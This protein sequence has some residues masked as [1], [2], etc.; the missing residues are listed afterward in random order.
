[1]M[2]LCLLTACGGTDDQMQAA[3]DLRTRLL[4]DGCSYTAQVTA[5]CGETAYTFT[6]ACRSGS[7][8]T[9]FTVLEP[10]A[11]AGI[12]ASMATGET[13]VT[14]DDMVLVFDDLAAGTVSAAAAPG[15][16]YSSWTGGY[17]QSCGKEGD[18][19]MATFLLGYDDEELRVDTW[20]DEN[21][22]PVSAEVYSG[23]TKILTCTLTDFT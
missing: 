12:T 7:E 11:I 19:T 2:L 21:G 18:Q 23:E 14:Y 22:Q 13:T 17:I 20:L 8:G 1:M 9:T 6:L 4:A 16:L 3:L 5:N 10:E 15:I